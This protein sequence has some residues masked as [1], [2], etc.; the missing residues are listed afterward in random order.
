MTEMK[1]HDKVH[2]IMGLEK[3][4]RLHFLMAQLQDVS[5]PEYKR[6]SEEY[7]DTFD[8]VSRGNDCKQDAL[9]NLG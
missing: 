9:F 3:V 8:A 1:I 7:N 5:N 2:Q 4:K 6:L